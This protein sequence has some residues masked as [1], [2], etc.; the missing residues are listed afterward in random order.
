MERQNKVETL[1]AFA[2]FPE[3]IKAA[4]CAGVALGQLMAANGTKEEEKAN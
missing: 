2:K 3:N 1:E 4:I